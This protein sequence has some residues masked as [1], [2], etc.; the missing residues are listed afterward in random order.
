M[1]KREKKGVKEFIYTYKDYLRIRLNNKLIFPG[2]SFVHKVI[3]VK[4]SM[5]VA[6]Q[7]P[8]SYF[9]ILFQNS[10][11]CACRV[12]QKKRKFPFVVHV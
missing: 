5:N 6:S 2:V 7:S 8:L 11:L 4:V 10:S 9:Y 12:L 3:N 1:D